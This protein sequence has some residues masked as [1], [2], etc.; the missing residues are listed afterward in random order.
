MYNEIYI[1]K[2][3]KKKRSDFVCTQIVVL[4]VAYHALTVD[5]L[6]QVLEINICVFYILQC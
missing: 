5:D 2:H 6:A 1:Y 4:I 3:S